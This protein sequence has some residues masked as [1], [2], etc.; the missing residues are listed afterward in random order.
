MFVHKAR[1]IDK[2][3]RLRTST[4]PP[5]VS[6]DVYQTPLLCPLIDSAQGNALCCARLYG[7]FPV[8]FFNQEETIM[9]TTLL[10]Q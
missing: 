10:G 3:N 6:K 9:I 2:L 7:V 5:K 4:K 1:Q 8:Y